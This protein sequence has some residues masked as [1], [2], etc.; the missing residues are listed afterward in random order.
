MHLLLCFEQPGPKFFLGLLFPQ[1]EFDIA[2]AVYCLG[3]LH[4]DLAKEFQLNVISGF[5]GL[6]SAG[7]C[8]AR[9]L[10]LDVAGFLRHVWRGDGEIDEVFLRDG[11]IGALGPED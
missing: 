3:V 9:R 4:I 1:D 11:G 6:R 8:E 10:Q 2:R 7:E 5:L